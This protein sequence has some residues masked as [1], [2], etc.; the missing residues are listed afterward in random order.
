MSKH[1]LHSDVSYKVRYSGEFHIRPSVIN[2]NGYKLVIDNNSGTYSPDIK[3]LPLLEKVFKVNF[4]DI[5]IET[6]DRSNPKLEEYM[7][8]CKK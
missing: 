3:C 1:A 7:K 4:P 6:L 2:K 8:D 5:E